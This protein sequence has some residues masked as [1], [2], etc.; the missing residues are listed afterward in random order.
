MNPVYSFMFEEKCQG[1]EVFHPKNLEKI[2]LGI[3]SEHGIQ[4]ESHI[5]QFTSLLISNN[6]D[7]EKRNIG[8]DITICFTACTDT[9]FEDMMDPGAITR[10]MG[11]VVRLLRKLMAEKK[12]SFNNAFDIDCQL[13]S[14][15]IQSMTLVNM[16]IDGSACT[17][18]LLILIKPLYQLSNYFFSNF[19]QMPDRLFIYLMICL[20]LTNL[21][22]YSIHIYTKIARQIG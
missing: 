13:K 12:N 15:P 6:D 8:S 14:I 7:L 18:V 5:S 16:F 4:Y 2:Y 3:L 21:Q 1:V 10:S 20:K 17:A 19:K 22:K 9:I 11:D